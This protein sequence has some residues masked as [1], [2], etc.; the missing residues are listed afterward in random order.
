M[1]KKTQEQK[2][3]Q[4]GADRHGKESESAEKKHTSDKQARKTPSE[5]EPAKISE[6]ATL[7]NVHTS[8]DLK[9][10]LSNINT[11]IEKIE[12][13]QA[14]KPKKEAKV[15]DEKGQWGDFPIKGMPVLSKNSKPVEMHNEHS[16]QRKPVKEIN[17]FDTK[18]KEKRHGSAKKETEPKIKYVSKFPGAYGEFK[19]SHPETEE[20]HTPE[21]HQSQEALQHLETKPKEEMTDAQSRFSRSS[22]YKKNPALKREQKIVDRKMAK[23]EYAKESKVSSTTKQPRYNPDKGDFE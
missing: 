22:A 8:K 9:S 18:E 5:Q 11:A 13:S 21:H 20:K 16:Q 12:K 15:P 23:N 3:T 2:N 10:A 1:A 17:V 7:D 19:K 14:Q 6:S 4:E